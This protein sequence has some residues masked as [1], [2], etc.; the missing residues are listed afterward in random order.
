MATVHHLPVEV[1]SIIFDL[2]HP[3]V[4]EESE[5]KVSVPQ[6]G[7][8]TDDSPTEDLKFI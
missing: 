7:I 6:Q 8:I 2:L 3:A 5:L 4:I 1:L